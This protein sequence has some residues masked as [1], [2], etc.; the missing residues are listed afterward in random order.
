MD[1]YGVEVS[2]GLI[3]TVTD[4]D[5][6]EIGQIDARAAHHRLGVAALGRDRVQLP[7]FALA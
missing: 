4:A 3:S 5:L 7:D 6:D 1:F 2:I